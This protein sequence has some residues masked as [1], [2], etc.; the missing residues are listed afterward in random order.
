MRCLAAFCLGWLLATTPVWAFR[1]SQPD[2]ITEWNENTFAQLN[3]ALLQLWN[4]T[5]GRY[6]P[7]VTTTDPDGSRVGSQ[8]DVI[9]YDPAAGS[10]EICVNVDGATDWDCATLS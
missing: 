8:Y 2:V 7:D 10:S 5:N 3:N 9:I 6:T 4:I 1:M